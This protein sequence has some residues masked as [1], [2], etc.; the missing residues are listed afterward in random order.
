MFWLYYLTVDA[1]F[2]YVYRGDLM[3]KETIIEM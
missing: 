2:N 3:T 1:V